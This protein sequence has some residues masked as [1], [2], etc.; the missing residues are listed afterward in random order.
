MFETESGSYA[1]MKRLWFMRR[2][3]EIWSN[4]GLEMLTGHSFHI[5]GTTHLLLMGVDPFIVMVQ[6]RW[7][8]TAFLEYWCRCEE[9]IPTFIGFS[10]ASKPSIPT[11][12]ESFKQWLIGSL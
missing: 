1:T 2:C 5:G 4:S 9:I 3:N 12:M 6:G 8:S 7:K 10:Q 11:S